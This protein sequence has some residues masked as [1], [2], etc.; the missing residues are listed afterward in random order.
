MPASFTQPKRLYQAH[1]PPYFLPSHC[2]SLTRGVVDDEVDA[3]L[4]QPLDGLRR[5]GRAC[6]RRLGELG[7]AGHAG[8]LEVLP[9]AL[10]CVDAVAEGLHSESRGG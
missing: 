8:R 2:Q 7:D 6:S 9:R 5:S 1:P 4:A 3:L 10:R